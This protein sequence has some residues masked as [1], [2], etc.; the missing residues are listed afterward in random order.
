MQTIYFTTSNYIR[1]EGNMVD[2][3]EYRRK[4]ALAQG[5][6]EPEEQEDV[7]P[8]RPRTVRRRRGALPGLMLDYAASIALII[9]ALSFA[10]KIL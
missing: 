5:H 8:V 4:L 3:T 2:L 9:T 1:H 7:P 6:A 10:A